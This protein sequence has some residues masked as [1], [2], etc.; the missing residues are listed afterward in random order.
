[1]VLP[2]E[3]KE[4]LK[5]NLNLVERITAAFSGVDERIDYT[6][7]LLTRMLE[8]LT[9]QPITPVPL[10]TGL[11]ELIDS[12]KALVVV[13]G[14]VMRNPKDVI[15]GRKLVIAAGTA[16]QLPSIIVPYDK[17]VIVKAPSTNTGTIYVALYKSDAEER[18]LAYPLV[19]GETVEYKILNL[20]KLWIDSTV[21][22]EGIVYTVEQE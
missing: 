17:A 5:Q 2:V 20:S 15:M 10:D 19:A 13:L 9:G 6:N 3:Y 11:Q 8:V 18:A 12:V 21:S 22:D 1:M 16:V 7:L 14:G 4:F